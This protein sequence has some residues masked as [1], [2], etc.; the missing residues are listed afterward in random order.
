M[1][2]EPRSLY[3]GCARQF[4]SCGVRPTRGAVRDQISMDFES[5]LC[6]PALEVRGPRSVGLRRKGLIERTEVAFLNFRSPDTTRPDLK[7]SRGRWFRGWRARLETAS[8]RYRNTTPLAIL[9]PTVYPSPG[10]SIWS[11]FERASYH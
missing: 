8:S 4:T 9:S 11:I 3:N 10:A 7:R 2:N 5:P 6:P 1:S